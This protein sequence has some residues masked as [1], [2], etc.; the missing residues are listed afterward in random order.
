MKSLSP[1]LS[2]SYF[3]NAVRQDQKLFP[4][5]LNIA[6]LWTSRKYI[7]GTRENPIV[8]FNRRTGAVRV[9]RTLFQKIFLYVTLKSSGLLDE[10]EN[11]IL[12]LRD[13]DTNRRL[14]LCVTVIETKCYDRF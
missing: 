9:Y 8:L 13:N 5:V 3:H 11:D 12:L 6:E 4:L 10:R 7:I 2:L 1:Y 14:C